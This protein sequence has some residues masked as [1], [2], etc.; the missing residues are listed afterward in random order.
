MDAAASRFGFSRLS[1]V[2]RNSSIAYFIFFS[3]DVVKNFFIGH[4][5]PL[6]MA[7]LLWQDMTMRAGEIVQHPEHRVLLVNFDY[8]AISMR[9]INVYLPAFG[10]VTEDCP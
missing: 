7:I 9:T 1:L 10:K 5:C 4:E 8:D 2:T 3:W 6:G